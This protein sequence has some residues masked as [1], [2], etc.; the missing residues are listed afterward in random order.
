[1]QLLKRITPKDLNLDDTVEFMSSVV[2]NIEIFN[3]TELEQIEKELDQIIN[4]SLKSFGD[5]IIALS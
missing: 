5:N 2:E 4:S 3:F 1:M